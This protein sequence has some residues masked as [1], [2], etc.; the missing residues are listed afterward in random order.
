MADNDVLRDLFGV[1]PPKKFPTKCGVREVP[2]SGYTVQKDGRTVY[3]ITGTRDIVKEVNSPETRALSG[4]DAARRLIASGA[5]LPNQFADDGT[6]G[7]IVPSDSADPTLSYEAARRAQAIFEK[8]KADLAAEGFDFSGITTAAD[9]N[10][11]IQSVVESKL[12]A[13]A[14]SKGGSGNEQK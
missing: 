4:L 6:K 10:A 11:Y 3:T 13:D 8:A 9:P 2:V 14:Q 12:A 5:A 7:G 1:I